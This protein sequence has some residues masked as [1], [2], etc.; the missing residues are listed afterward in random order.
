MIGPPKLS[1][2]TPTGPFNY[3]P[4]PEKP[5]YHAQAKAEKLVRRG[6]REFYIIA[7]KPDGSRTEVRLL[8]GR[9][10]RSS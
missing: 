5:G 2:V 9:I 4:Y 8:P 10:R 1:A 7:R 3:Q 6:P